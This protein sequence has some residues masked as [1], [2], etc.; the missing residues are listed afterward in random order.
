MKAIKT[1]GAVICALAI[2]AGPA[3]AADAKEKDSKDAKKAP[4]C[5][6]AKAAGKECEHACCVKSAKEGK[7]CEKCSK[8]KED[9]K[10]EEKKN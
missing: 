8:S 5:E 7:V 3:I 10:K 4:C 9:K 6:K 2:L 1:L